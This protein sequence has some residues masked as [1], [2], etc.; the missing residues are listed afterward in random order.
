MPEEGETDY[1][2]C[3]EEQEGAT[4]GCDGGRLFEVI[5]INPEIFKN[6]DASISEGD[7][8]KKIGE[9]KMQQ[10]INIIAA[11]DKESLEMIAD[12]RKTMERFQ[13]QQ[14]VRVACAVIQGFMAGQHSMHVPTA[15]KE[16]VAIAD[17]LIEELERTKHAN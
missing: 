14:R 7:L 17:A 4:S 10:E 15:V 5:E 2:R 12:L 11:L 8:V 1:K 16:S 9:P 13:D 3:S 6:A